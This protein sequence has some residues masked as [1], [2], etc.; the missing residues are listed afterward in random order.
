MSQDE[1]ISPDLQDIVVEFSG[2]FCFFSWTRPIN[3]DLLVVVADKRVA[4]G[5][6]KQEIG[7]TSLEFSSISELDC[8]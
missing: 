3:L 2:S 7:R 1:Q 6:E 8:N 4:A 5:Q